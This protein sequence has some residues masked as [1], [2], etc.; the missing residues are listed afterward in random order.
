MDY[1]VHTKGAPAGAPA[2]VDDEDEGYTIG[3]ENPFAKRYPP[4][5][6]EIKYLRIE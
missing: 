6:A 3:A 5:E 2:A 4:D 1:K